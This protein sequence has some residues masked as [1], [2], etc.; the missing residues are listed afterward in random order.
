MTPEQLAQMRAVTSRIKA[1]IHTD[2]G[3]LSATAQTTVNVLN[4]APTVGEITAPVDPVAVGTAIEASADFTDPGLLD[5]HTAAW[6][7]G[8]GNVDETSGSGSVTGSHTYTVAGVYEVTLTVIDDDGGSGQSVFRYVVIYDPS[9]GF[10]TGGGWIDS[11]QGAYTPDPSL[12]GK[13][14]FGFV[15]KYKYQKGADTPSGETEFQ[16]KVADLNFHSTSYQWLVIAG[17][18][19]QF[20][21]SGTVNGSGDYGFMLTATDGQINGG[22]GVDKFRIKIW[23]KETDEVIYDNQIGDADDSDATL[24]IGGG[25]IV[26][27]SK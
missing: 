17:A 22:G 3:G 8:D 20:K 26:I 27:H 1:P 6:D 19:A 2:S 4:V 16:F 11:P 25:S 5:T 14:N 23:D 24:A 12:T 9:A 18:K 13:T 10:V 7:W 21:G 15:A